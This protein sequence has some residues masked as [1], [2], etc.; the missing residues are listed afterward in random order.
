MTNGQ[1]SV[2]TEGQPG[3][4]RA[5]SSVSLEK[6]RLRAVARRRIARRKNAIWV[7]S[8]SR[9][10]KMRT[11]AVCAGALLLM[12]LGLYFGLSHQESS[13]PVE[14]VAPMGAVSIV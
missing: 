13:G 3:G 4:N 9:R 5:S 1:A 7:G 10:E 12:A 14:S 6:M 2:D 11:M 8:R